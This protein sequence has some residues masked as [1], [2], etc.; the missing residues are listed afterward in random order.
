M[1]NNAGDYHYTLGIFNT[2]PQF[3]T[4]GMAELTHGIDDERKS[5]IKEL[6]ENYTKLQ[7]ALN[8]SEV[9]TTGT[10]DPYSGGYMFLRYLAK[11]GSE[12][13][14]SA[15]ANSNANVTSNTKALTAQSS[16]VSLSGNVLTV[17]SKPSDGK[18]DLTKYSLSVRKVDASKL[19]GGVM[20][21]GNT[22]ANSIKGGTGADT[23]SANTGNDSV[24]GGAGNDL[25]FGDAGNDFL[26]GE[27]G[28]DT[29]IG[30]TGTNS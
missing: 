2:L 24:Y 26:Y 25:I 4:E 21:I 7:N 12:H 27:V 23:V 17:T 1:I 8:L 19:T 22:Y 20:I 10:R 11:Q 28:N 3:I 6:A 9:G 30:G 15:T 18:I 14:G 29:L 13:Y 16:N 5:N